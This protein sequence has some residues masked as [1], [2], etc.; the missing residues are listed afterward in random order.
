MESRN[1]VAGNVE[2]PKVTGWLG[3]Q[4]WLRFALMRKSWFFCQKGAMRVRG[5][6]GWATIDDIIC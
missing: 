4:L 5:Q 3:P 1:T 6:Q 2:L